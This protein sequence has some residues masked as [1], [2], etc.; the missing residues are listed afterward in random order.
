VGEHDLYE[1]TV[2]V[3]ITRD[4]TRA[5]R[6]SAPAQA[7]LV[8]IAGPRLGHRVVLD[9]QPLEIGRGSQCGLQL[10]VDSVSRLHARV[11]WT[12]QCHKV[13]DNQSTNGTYVNEMRVSDHELHDA[14]R[15]QIGK[16][17]LK[18][19]SGSNVESA[20]HEEIQRLMRFDGLTGIHN[21]SHFEETFHNLVWRAR[22]DPSPTS[23][24]LFDLDHFKS[25]N[26]TFG[27]T[28]GD[29]V[30]RQVSAVVSQQV[31]P[32]QL[33]ARVGG[34][35]FAV[36]LSGLDLQAACA[37][38]EQIRRAVE[39]TPFS[40]DGNRIPV[41]ISAGVADRQPTDQAPQQLYERA[42]SRLYAAKG[43]GRNCVR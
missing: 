13:V 12:G 40:F 15:L 5:L 2:E 11:E 33:F 31:P 10:D 21:R 20:Y 35:E 3:T 39:A 25:I 29:A 42:D 34:E 17:L 32:G 6:R 37:I 1:T 38:A 18:Y 16:V 4:F 28:A 26:D 19:I 24:I 8:V 36:L 22:F 7:Y 14:D 41:T 43:S 23:L 27:H 30:L 9:E